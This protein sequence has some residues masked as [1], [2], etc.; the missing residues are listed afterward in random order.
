MTESYLIGITGG[1]GSG[2]THFLKQLI[3]KFSDDQLCLL[4]QDNY[5]HERS[6]QPID[7]DG[8]VNFDTPDSLDLPLFTEHL[9]ALKSGKVVEKSE[10]VFNNPNAIAKTLVFKPAPIIIVEGIFVF[11]FE[12]IARQLNLKVFIEAPSYMKLKRRIIRDNTERGY[13]LEDVL[14][15]YENH[16]APTYSKYIEPY[17]QTSDIIIPNQDNMDSALEVIEGFIQ[18]RLK[19]IK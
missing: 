19:E 9:K 1:S 14:Y 8:W 15:R 11:H 13:D 16:V 6:Q 3:E 18:S 2:K 17:K 12:A 5:Y 10:Y 7:E 4:S